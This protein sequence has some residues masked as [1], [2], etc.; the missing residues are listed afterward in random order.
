MA[1]APEPVHAR[2]SPSSAY[3][4]TR[5]TAS[6]GFI[7]QNSAIL[8]KDSTVYADEGTEA[9][10]WAAKLL[11]KEVRLLSCGADMMTH[12]RA[13]VDFV[14]DKVTPKSRLL[15]EKRIK[16]FYNRQQHGTT[17]AAIISPDGIYICDLKYGAGVSVY[18]HE[19]QQ[20]AIYAESLIQE[21]EI[22]EEIPDDRL[23]TLAI[24]QPRDRNDH[25]PV[26][27]WALNRGELREFCQHIVEAQQ[28][29]E[30]GQ[31]EFKADPDKQCRFCPAAGICQAYAAHGLAPIEAN[32]DKLELPNPNLITR[33][34]RQKVLAAK[35][36]ISAW[37]EAVE[38]QE[39]NELLAGAAPIDFKLVE[40]KTNRVWT[41]E[42]EVEKR[43]LKFATPDQVRPPADLVSPAAAQKIAKAAN[44]DF[45][46][47]FEELITKPQ[48]KPTLVPVTDKRP[49]LELNPASG[50][51]PYDVI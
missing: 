7:E 28:R 22:I 15:V 33:E 50:F 46:L 8:P 45:E 19:N 37:L 26:R 21:L 9:H 27:L 51:T 6:I 13:Y 10:N 17:D 34:Q 47:L 11:T 16:L 30:A 40:G 18:A 2:L 48:G 49:A 39:K 5:C 14:Q 3:R 36:A 25:N 4:W 41:D 32:V 20:L 38:D 24:F 42:K 23:V 1:T 35:K 43:L 12:V 29:I 31:V 44:V